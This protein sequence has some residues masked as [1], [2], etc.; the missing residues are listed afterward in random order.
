METALDV[1]NEI[2]RLEE[3]ILSAKRQLAELR[4][5]AP[6]EP[7]E[8]HVLR[9]QDGGEVRL[10]ELFQDKPDLILVH[11]MGRGCSYCTMWADGLNG[12]LPHLEDRAAFVV[13]SPDPP[14][15]Q[16]A[17][18]ASRGWRFQMASAAGTP[19]TR[20]AGYEE[21]DGAPLPGVS[22][23]RKRDDGRIERVAHTE[24]GPGDDFCSVWHLFDLLEGGPAGWE[25]Q[26][27]YSRQES[28]SLA[29]A[30]TG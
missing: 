27:R 17:L 24:F 13:V 23:F 20:L 11:N 1:V 25:P 22:T 15:V 14:E 21:P 2:H 4:Q 30:A 18:A 5:L 10:S 6:R 16:K 8:D 3:E 9:G 7:F 29:T 19:F 26:K 28:R 12:V